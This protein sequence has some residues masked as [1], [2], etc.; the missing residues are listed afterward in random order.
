MLSFQF[1]VSKTKTNWQNKE[2]W[3]ADYKATWK[4]RRENSKRY[5]KRKKKLKAVLDTTP[6]SEEDDSLQ[7]IQ[8]ANEVQEN[9]QEAAPKEQPFLSQQ[10]HVPV[11]KKSNFQ[12]CQIN[13]F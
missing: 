11:K 6:S 2:N 10:V 7:F 4:K 1:Q 12:F 13:L 9:L 3:R 8:E 5:Y